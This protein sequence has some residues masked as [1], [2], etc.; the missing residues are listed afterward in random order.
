ML[1]KVTLDAITFLSQ[2]T[3]QPTNQPTIMII[4]EMLRAKKTPIT[5]VREAQYKRTHEVYG[6]APCE[7]SEKQGATHTLYCGEGLGRGTR[8]AKLLKTVLYVGL[9]EE[10]DKI[11]WTKWDIKT[12]WVFENA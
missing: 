2:E 1:T 12:L 4:E 10:E 3:N 5:G 7:W 11:I 9:D 8:P 6:S